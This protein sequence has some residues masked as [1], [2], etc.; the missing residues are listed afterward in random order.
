MR[1]E[2]IVALL[3]GVVALTSAA[4]TIWSALRNAARG[5]EN[6]RAIKQLEIDNARAIKQLEI[7][8]DRIKIADQRQKELSGYTE[9]LARSAYDLQGRLYNILQQNFVGYYLRN[10]TPREKSYAINNTAFLIGQYLCWTELVRRDIQFI[11]LGENTTT[12]Q[13]ARLQD[14]IYRLWGTSRYST[15]FRIWAG[16]QR[17]LGEVLIQIGTRG[18][19]CI[20]YGAFRKTFRSSTDPLIDALREDIAVLA[21]N[22]DAASER[23]IRLQHAFIDLLNVLDPA[24][25]RFPEELRLKVP[26]KL[27][28][29][30]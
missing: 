6:A 18:P 22:L 8:Y 28:L 26:D 27:I 30:T 10:G 29:K 9:P 3:A 13:L 23:L 20:G 12:R 14:S 16:E 17:A 4:G 21:D 15:V 2:L 25:L 24:R 11:N 19:E 1:T 7:D 5:N